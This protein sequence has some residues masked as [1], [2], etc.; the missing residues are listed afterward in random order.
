MTA[1]MTGGGW[2]V[3]DLARKAGL[4]YKT[5]DR[6]LSGD[7]QTTKTAAKLAAAL[8]RPITR[9]LLRIKVVA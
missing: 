5:A 2:S 8:G 3:V 9:Y 6:F 1:D 4:S 7:V